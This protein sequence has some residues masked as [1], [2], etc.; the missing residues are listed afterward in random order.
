MYLTNENAM[1]H[2]QKRQSTHLH[3]ESPISD[4]QAI[5]GILYF[6][7]NLG[8]KGKQRWKNNGTKSIFVAHL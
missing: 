1:K 5:D 3:H 2:F 7:V 4:I 6:T 8:K